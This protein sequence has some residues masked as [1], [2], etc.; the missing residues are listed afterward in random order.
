VA[1]P[2]LF[3]VAEDAMI[4]RTYS[5]PAW[6]QAERTLMAYFARPHEGHP[7]AEDLIDAVSLMTAWL[8]VAT[9]VGLML[10]VLVEAW[11]R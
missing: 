2:L 5:L 1:A 9:S 7:Y 3:S 8:M 6:V 10:T 11:L 4:T